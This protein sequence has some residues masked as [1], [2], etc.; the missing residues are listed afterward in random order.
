MGNLA[1]PEKSIVEIVNQV[2]S[3]HK[4]GTHQVIRTL[5]SGLSLVGLEDTTKI[6][7]P[8]LICYQERLQQALSK[9][10]EESEEFSELKEITRI[11][12]ANLETMTDVCDN[13]SFLNGKSN[14]KNINY[15]SGVD[16]NKITEFNNVIKQLVEEKSNLYNKAQLIPSLRQ[17]LEEIKW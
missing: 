11:S 12:F 5:I 6:L 17:T 15:V 13:L 16:L 10:F 1:E 9:V 14:H 2:L 8:Q 3:E 7:P 4:L